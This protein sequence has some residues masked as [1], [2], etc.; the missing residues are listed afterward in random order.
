MSVID[1][2]YHPVTIN[3]ASN[4]TEEAENREKTFFT[5]DSG[6]WHFTGIP[7]GICNAP[8]GKSFE[9][10][11]RNWE[12]LFSRLRI[13]GL[14]LSPTKGHIL[15]KELHYLS[16]VVSRE[17]VSVYKQKVK[18]AQEWPVPKDVQRK[19]SLDYAPSNIGMCLYETHGSES[20]V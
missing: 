18:V 16:H 4:F 14:T 17:G 9:D 6:L 19:N 15:Q 12:E 5:V 11:I 2:N 7:V 3:Q 10:Q 8:A 13:S 20:T 1:V